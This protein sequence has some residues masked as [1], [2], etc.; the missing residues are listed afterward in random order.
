MLDLPLRPSCFQ[1]SA[2]VDGDQPERNDK[3]QHVTIQYEL[4]APPAD[5]R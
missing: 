1:A 5:A 3:A 2:L 4:Q